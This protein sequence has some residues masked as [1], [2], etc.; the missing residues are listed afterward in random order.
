MKTRSKYHRKDMLLMKKHQEQLK[1]IGLN[2]AYYRK[3][4]GMS[5]LDITEVLDVPVVDLVRNRNSMGENIPP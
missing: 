5:Q 2:I 3:L 4:K 1:I